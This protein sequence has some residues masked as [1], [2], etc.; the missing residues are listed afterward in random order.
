[1]KRERAAPFN[2][3]FA[4]DAGAVRRAAGERPEAL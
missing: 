1:L 4:F 3:V 2:G